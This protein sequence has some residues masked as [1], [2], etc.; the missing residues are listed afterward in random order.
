MTKWALLAGV[1]FLGCSVSL[2]AQERQRSVPFTLNQ[3]GRTVMGNRGDL[4]STLSSFYYSVP[5]PM[6]LDGR[7]LSLSYGYDWIEPM[8]PDFLPE[9]STRPARVGT[10]TTAWRDSR[11]KTLEVQPKPFSYAYGEV[12][13]FYGTSTGGKFSREVKQGHVFG[14]MGNDKTHISVGVSYEDSNGHV[15]RFGR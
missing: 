13:V 4:L 6:L 9:L 15:P 11:D 10:A 12:S 8:P 3:P 14:E 1:G 2:S 5:A 7:R